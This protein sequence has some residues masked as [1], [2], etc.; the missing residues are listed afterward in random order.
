MLPDGDSAHGGYVSAWSLSVGET[1]MLPQR[2][3]TVL[4]LLDAALGISAAAA[5]TNQVL[6]DQNHE[7]GIGWIGL[8]R[9]Q[10]DAFHSRFSGNNRVAAL[11][12]FYE[13]LDQGQKVRFAGI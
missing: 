13:A 12:R 1:P 4:Q 6:R 3:V 2:S 7:D 9:M 5:G 10:P 11:M 8:V